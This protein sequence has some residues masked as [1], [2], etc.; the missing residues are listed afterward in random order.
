MNENHLN[1][2]C[3]LDKF[4]ERII[5]EHHLR[6]WQNKIVNDDLDSSDNSTAPSESPSVSEFVHQG[7][8]DNLMKEHII[9]SECI[10][11]S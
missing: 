10:Q 9:N 3:P 11:Q 1:I 2:I 4:G 5:F 6:I 8:S 7:C